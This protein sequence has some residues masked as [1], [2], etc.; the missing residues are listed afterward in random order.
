MH[1]A[2]EIPCDRYETPFDS[3]E[4]TR[5]VDAALDRI[6]ARLVE[7]EARLDARFDRLTRQLYWWS[8]WL[9]LEVLVGF[10]LVAWW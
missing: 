7:I 6:E 9:T 8:V 3:D 2:D 5:R 1:D 4:E 10:G